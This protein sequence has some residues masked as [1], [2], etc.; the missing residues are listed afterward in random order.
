MRRL[1]CLG[2]GEQLGNGADCEICWLYLSDHEG[3]R[4]DD[5]DLDTRYPEPAELSD[6]YPVG[7]H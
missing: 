5:S 6:M 2:C 1:A 4:L 3:Q 7:D